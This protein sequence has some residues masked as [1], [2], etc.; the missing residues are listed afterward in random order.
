MVKFIEI[1][2]GSAFYLCKCDCGVEKIKRGTDIKLGRIKSCGCLDMD[3][4]RKHGLHKTP[5][6]YVWLAMRSR[7]QKKN[8]KD[9]KYYGGRGIKLCKRWEDPLVF[10]KDMGPRPKGYSIERVNNNGDYKPS[11]CKWIPIK[12]Q[13]KNRRNVGAKVE[14]DTY[15]E[16]K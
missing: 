15:K 11:N 7:C 12:D 5:E 13:S 1:R 9:Y 14:A 3:R 8:H 16:V 4:K 10:I 2:K 6:Y